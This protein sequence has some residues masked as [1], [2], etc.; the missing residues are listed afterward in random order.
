[1]K[2]L[3]VKEAKLRD[4]EIFSDLINQWAGNSL[5]TKNLADVL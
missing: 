2:E 1:M 4:T 5:P 3:F